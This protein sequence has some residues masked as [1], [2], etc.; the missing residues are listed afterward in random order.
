[1]DQIVSA[2]W[3]LRRALIAESG[4][5][6]LS[7]DGGHWKEGRGTDVFLVCKQ[8]SSADDM[9]E[10]MQ[11][12]RLGSSVLLG[13]LGTV[14]WAIEREGALPAAAVQEFAKHFR[15]KPSALTVELENLLQKQE[16][17]ASG[18][19][20]VVQPEANK[21]EALAL[22]DERIEE[23]RHVRDRCAEHE[24]SIEC[25]QEAAAVLP[26]AET[27]DRI[28]RYETKLERQL[29]RAMAQL[30]RVQRMRSGEAIPA[31]LSV[32]ISDRG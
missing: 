15:D 10:A 7:V 22:I 28:L 19:D 27:L 4:E 30:E 2:H 26:S 21:V 13:W 8:W 12:T 31:P 29:Y 16:S 6:A 24:N 11:R 14:R 23:L 17:N 9:E 25:A 5:I 3:R 1:V 32:E 18:P 20:A